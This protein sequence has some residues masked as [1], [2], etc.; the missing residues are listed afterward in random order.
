MSNNELTRVIDELV[1][2]KTFGLDAL[3]AIKELR[4][5]AQAQEETIK[6]REQ[7]AENQQ[8]KIAELERELGSAKARVEKLMLREANLLER[9]KA[10][11]KAIYDAERHRAVADAWRAAMGMVFKPVEVRTS[12]QRQVALPASGMNSYPTTMPETE[13]TT[14]TQE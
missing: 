4:D 5:K 2:K 9:E 7:Q 1:E 8:R 14:V 3:G 13:T 6:A 11:D 12:I 10:A